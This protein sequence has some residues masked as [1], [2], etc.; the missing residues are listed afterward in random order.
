MNKENKVRKPT[1]AMQYDAL[2]FPVIGVVTPYGNLFEQW[3]RDI[4]VRLYGDGAKYKHI[5]CIDAIRGC[6]FYTVE[7]GYKYWEVDEVVYNAAVL[8]VR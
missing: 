8:R 3:K 7:K 6:E 5:R 1:K 2:L 4:G